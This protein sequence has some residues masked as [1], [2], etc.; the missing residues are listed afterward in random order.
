M[1]KQRV[2]ELFAE[3]IPADEVEK[4]RS[5][6]YVYFMKLLKGFSYGFSFTLCHRI[7][8]SQK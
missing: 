1:Q 2:A 3:D 8:I 6:K 5:G 7:G 4:T